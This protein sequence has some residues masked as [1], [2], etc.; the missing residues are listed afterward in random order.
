VLIEFKIFVQVFFARYG[1]DLELV[2]GVKMQIQSME[3]LQR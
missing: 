3:M 1:D 2:Q